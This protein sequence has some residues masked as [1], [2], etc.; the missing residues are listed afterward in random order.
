[1][2][3]QSDI[4]EILIRYRILADISGLV[5]DVYMTVVSPLHTRE[6]L[7]CRRYSL[8]LNMKYSRVL[9]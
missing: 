7:S 1:M 6:I 4:S 3:G 2:D 9:L 5:Y 8:A